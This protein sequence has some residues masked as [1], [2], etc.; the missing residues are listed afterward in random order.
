MVF[1]RIR[2]RHRSC[3]MSSRRFKR[4]WFHHFNLV[5][6][7][8]ISWFFSITGYLMVLYLRTVYSYGTISWTWSTCAHN[9]GVLISFFPNSLDFPFYHLLTVFSSSECTIILGCYPLI[10]WRHRL[11]NA[12]SLCDNLW[13]LLPWRV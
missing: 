10:S 8:F 1:L 5:R 4:V 2:L 7:K 12:R 13:L 6:S 11:R 9:S 3:F